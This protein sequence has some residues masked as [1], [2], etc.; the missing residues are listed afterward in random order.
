MSSCSAPDDPNVREWMTSNAFRRI[1]DNDVN[2]T[3][4]MAGGGI[5]VDSFVT[6]IH[7]RRVSK[8]RESQERSHECTRAKQRGGIAAGAAAGDV[9]LVVVLLQVTVDSWV[10]YGA[11]VRLRVRVGVSVSLLLR[12]VQMR[13]APG[14]KIP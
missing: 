9:L 4:G 5:I 2:G 13:E 10:V 11:E 3:G 6:R 1:A 7:P 8:S 14:G 12:T